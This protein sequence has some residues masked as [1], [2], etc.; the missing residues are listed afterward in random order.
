MA[1]RMLASAALATCLLSLGAPVAMAAGWR[2]VESGSLEVV[3]AECN[4]GK[5]W[6]AWN[7][8]D[9]RPRRDGGYDLFVR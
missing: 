5:A 6:G 4:A 2:Y 8:C 1:R 7:E 9:I 3:Q